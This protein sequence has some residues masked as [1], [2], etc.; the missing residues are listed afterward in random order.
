[1]S[2]CRGSRGH[3]QNVAPIWVKALDLL[4]ALAALQPGTGPPTTAFPLR[5]LAPPSLPE[6]LRLSRQCRTSEQF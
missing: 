2:R 4:M 6:A 3:A 5:P 1:M